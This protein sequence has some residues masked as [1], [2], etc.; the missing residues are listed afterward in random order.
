[1]TFADPL[2]GR[3]SGKRSALAL[4]ASRQSAPRSSDGGLPER[5]RRSRPPA[6]VFQLFERLHVRARNEQALARPADLV[7][8]TVLLQP[9]EVT[10][11]R[12]SPGM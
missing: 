12:V 6:A 8:P 5:R 3:A 10:G 1:M 7:L 4:N 11:R 2:K 9:A